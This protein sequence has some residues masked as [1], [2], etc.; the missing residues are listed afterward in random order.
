[1]GRG[2]RVDYRQLKAFERKLAKL[3][4][5]DYEKF[6]EACAKE[7]AARLLREVINNTSVITGTL[8]RGWTAGKENKNEKGNIIGIGGKSGYANSLEVVRNGD[9]FEITVFNNTEYASY[10]EYG[11]RTRNHKGWVNGRF[12]MTI[13]ADRIEGRAPAILEKKLYTMLKEAFDGD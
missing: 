5:V 3:A 1:M 8:R 2:G 12:T 4:K 10:Y 13:A 11:H 7:L 6:C 9:I